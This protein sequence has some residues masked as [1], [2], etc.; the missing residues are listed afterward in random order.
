MNETEEGKARTEVAKARKDK[1]TKAK[2]DK[3]DD[4]KDDTDAERP[5]SNRSPQRLTRTEGEKRRV[6]VVMFF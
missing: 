5:A 2:Q 3:D 1:Y 4:K 6:P